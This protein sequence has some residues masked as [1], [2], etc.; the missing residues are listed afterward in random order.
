MKAITSGLMALLILA[1]FDYAGAETKAP[2]VAVFPLETKGVRISPAR[3]RRLGDYLTMALA[4]A[5]Q[6]QV[7]PR[8]QLRKALAQ[9]KRASYKKCYEQSCHV[10]L[11]R[12]LAA[13]KS[14]ATVIV[15]FGSQ[16]KITAVLYDLKTAASERGARLAVACNESAIADAIDRLVTQLG[17]AAPTSKPFLPA[18]PIEPTVQDPPMPEAISDRRRE[19]SPAPSEDAVELKT[20]AKLEVKPSRRTQD[21]TRTEWFAIDLHGGAGSTGSPLG[22]LSLRFFNLKWKNFYLNALDLGVM[23]M[24]EKFLGHVGVDAGYP[25]YLGNR[26]QHQ[27]RF[28]VGAHAFVTFSDTQFSFAVMP[29]ISYQY[30]TK[31]S[32]FYGAGT[33][34]FILPSGD[35]LVTVGATIGWSSSIL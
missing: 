33:R 18:P 9:Q 26:G 3:V 2:I 35:A 4:A 22:G 27:L 11:G 12:E 20:S 29:T 8:E 1:S 5:G 16:C 28:G 25:V 17:A 34:I 23:T 6:Y 21:A 15:Q 31:G 13:Q 19:T 24:S 32:T 14:L 10:E 30:Q 7:V